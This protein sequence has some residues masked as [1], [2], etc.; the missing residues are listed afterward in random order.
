MNWPR[1]LALIWLPLVF[2]ARVPLAAEMVLYVAPNGR[3]S[4]SGR[5]ASP[6]DGDGPLATPVG[7]RDRIRKMRKRDGGVKTAVRVKIASG[8]YRLRGTLVFTPEDSGTKEFPVVYEA[9]DGAAPV[10]SGGR[11]VKGWKRWEKGWTADVK[12]P[13]KSA[14]NFKQLFVDGLRGTRARTPN[15]EDYWFFA[16][17]GATVKEGTGEIFL[18]KSDALKISGWKGAELFM[19]R[20]WDVSRYSV[21]AFDRKA[22]RLSFHMPKRET[23]VSHWGADRRFFLENSLSFLDAPGE[24]F[25]NV[26]TGR[27]YLKP[28]GVFLPQKTEVVAPAMRH[29]VRFAGK[30]GKPV[31]HLVFRGLTFRHADWSIPEDGYHG[32]QADV[33][34]G[35]AIEGD[36]VEEVVFEKCKVENVGA[37]AI[38]LRRG[39][40]NNRIES[41]EFRDLGAGG[42]MIGAIVDPTDPAEETKGNQVLDC[43]LSDNGRVFPGACGIWVGFA[44][45]NRIAGNHVHH[46]TYTGISVGWGWSDKPNGGHHNL[47]E[48]N[49]VHDVM[50]VMGDGGCIYTLGRQPGTVI[51]NNICHDTQGFYTYGPGI[52]L[53]GASAEITVENNLVARTIGAS[54]VMH[55]GGRHKIRNNIFALAGSGVIHHSRSKG[56][57]IEGNIIYFDESCIFNR[58]W[59]KEHGRFERNLYFNPADA[60][61]VWE[62]LSFEDWQRMGQDAGSIVAD[63]RFVDVEGGNF[64]LRADSPAKRIGFKPFR[65]PVIGP[66][67]PDRRRSERMVRLF[68]L[69]RLGAR[70]DAITPQAVAYEAAAQR[71]TGLRRDV[72]PAAG[73]AQMEKGLVAWW[74][75]EQVL[76]RRKRRGI[77]GKIFMNVRQV[78]GVLGGA[79]RLDGNRARIEAPAIKALKM[80]D[81]VTV[82]AWV[83]LPPKQVQGKASIGIVERSQIYRLLVSNDRAPYRINFGVFL[84]GRKHVGV[85]SK[86]IVQPN[87]WTFLAGTFDSASGEVALY[88]NGQL[89]AKAKSD[90]GRKMITGRPNLVI[91]RRDGRTYLIGVVDEVKIYSRALSAEEIE[92]AYRKVMATRKGRR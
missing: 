2:F 85:T 73:A 90:R 54:L 92:A 38:W 43:E 25:L 44:G 16:K 24:W 1:R 15:V 56:N 80:T 75:F 37:Y 79:V 13:G 9:A 55:S 27:V 69:D 67:P 84:E 59:E 48:N 78:K 76:D 31:E 20:M 14:W 41:C 35:A 64:A 72:V 8:T 7:A 52:Y 11:V 81:A 62:G 29:L 28:K 70:W 26:R 4:W 51:R 10:I 22:G 5:V 50:Q 66:A 19:Y 17:G 83:K 30:A 65:V 68:T 21:K 47:V 34:V 42:V 57:T 6:S 63:P 87:R 58:P 45:Y 88:V 49:H 60:T 71:P 23:R 36:F 77:D 18:Q 46:T 53:D 39:C 86:R 89:A 3:D 12:E 91:G 33:V 32:H 82:S 61:E 40:R 74:P